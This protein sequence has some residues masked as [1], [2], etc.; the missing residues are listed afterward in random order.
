MLKPLLARLRAA[1]PHLRAWLIVS[2][3]VG[4]ATAGADIDRMLLLASQRYG[5]AGASAVTAWRNVLTQSAGLAEEVRLRR[6]NDFFNRR[7]RFDEDSTIWGQSDYWATPLETLGRAQGDCEDFAIAKYVTLKLVGVPS[8]KLRLTYVKARIG[9][10]QSTIVQAH[11][12]LSY[13]PTPDAE[14]LVLDNLV[15]DIRPASRRPDL[16]TIFGFNADGMWVGGARPRAASSTKLSK[17]QSVL[18]RMREEGIE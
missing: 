10:P 8:D 9:G 12:V 6:V 17:W 7:V 2:L 18:L 14:P 4:L 1:S 15:S 11:M 16:T 5:D 3:G 13:Y